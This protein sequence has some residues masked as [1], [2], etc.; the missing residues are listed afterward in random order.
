MLVRGGSENLQSI[1]AA[2][3]RPPPVGE[4]GL[5]HPWRDEGPAVA[6]EAEEPQDG[7][8]LLFVKWPFPASGEA[9]L[10]LSRK[11]EQNEPVG[12]MPIPSP[13]L[14]SKNI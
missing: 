13:S 2:G 7:A 6:P 11:R 8:L 4:D 14:G 12:A 1:L 9:R 3:S 5:R 10:P